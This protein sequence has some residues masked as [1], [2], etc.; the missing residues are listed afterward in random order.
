MK[1]THVLL[2]WYR[3]F[4]INYLPY[5]DRREGTLSRPW[6]L[7]GSS[8]E[9]A[10]KFIEIPIKSDIT[11]IVG[12]NESGKSHL[13]SAINKVLNGVG[14]PDADEKQ[15]EFHFTDLC[16]YAGEQ[17]KNIETWPNIGLRFSC[18]HEEMT[19]VTSS[20]NAK[21]K[22]LSKAFTLV[23]DRRGSQHAILYIDGEPAIPLS[24]EQLKSIR[25]T[26]PTV[27][28]I[29]STRPMSDEIEIEDLL[30]ALASGT[31]KENS[32]YPFEAS[33][34]ALKFLTA[35]TLPG[36]GKAITAD[37][38]QS[39]SEM[40][41][42]LEKS[43]RR[44]HAKVELELQL[45]RDVLK[46]EPATLEQIARLGRTGRSFVD[47]LMSVWNHE[48]E[49]E[50]NLS[51]YWQQ[52]DAFRL[53]LNYKAGVFYFE[54]TDKTGAVYTFKER[55]SGLRYFLSYYIQA[56]ALESKAVL[57]GRK[58]C[59]FLMDEPDSFLSIVGQRNLMNVFESLVFQSKLELGTQLIY[60]THS[61]FL[62]NKNFPHRIRLVRKG[63]GE[64]GTQFVDEARVRRYEPV[65]SALGIDCAQ[66]L[67]MGESN[68]IVEGPTDQYLL[69]ELVRLYSVYG[70]PNELL[71]LNSI[72]LMSAESAPGVEK[73]LLASRWGDEPIPATVVI[74]D[75]DVE[76]KLQK[77]RVTGIA[78]GCKKLI[79]E[80]FVLLISDLVTPDGDGQPISTIEDIVPRNIYFSA[81]RSYLTEWY[82]REEV[83]EEVLEKASSLNCDKCVVECV[84]KF[85][86]DEVHGGK[87]YDKMGVLQ[88]VI[89]IVKS[90]LGTEDD[91]LNAEVEI[92]K[93][94]LVALCS[95]LRRK[96]AESKRES[97]AISTSG[98]IKRA[99]RDFF[100][101]F[102]SSANS[103]DLQLLLERCNTLAQYVGDDAK[104]LTEVSKKLLDRI[105][106]M[107][108]A[109]ISLVK[110]G[111]WGKWKKAL[112]KIRENPLSPEEVDFDDPRTEDVVVRKPDAKKDTRAT[113]EIEPK[114]NKKLAANAPVSVKNNPKDVPPSAS[115]E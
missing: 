5:S 104:G 37:L 109:D 67:F 61:P 14:I 4:N 66:T 10:Y 113:E 64:E 83:S 24:D 9:D 20:I 44:H 17:K 71:D 36:A 107:R 11:T 47:G 77:D 39:V 92:L 54:I 105:H 85:F 68:V 87:T 13:V 74:F 58:E 76:G 94:T 89:S 97:K 81:L 91:H 35:L 15:K 93:K 23:L 60:T 55:S 53:G 63:D 41:Q 56:K 46:I 101:R 59:I 7:I 49:R 57:E 99:V 88:E 50:L 40:Q 21:P 27:E 1:I 48:L 8:D 82:S 16:H 42:N 2:R 75:D 103:F 100:K 19:T 43:K 30:S 84:S 38:H 22:S 98:T 96:I 65:R 102:K 72:V 110:D 45:F 112:T 70:N 108:K 3:S 28:F 52:D 111:S 86:E 6:N 90:T 34:D 31:P 69:A 114:T 79:D 115:S 32:Y 78:R 26:L 62:I 51:H 12:G 18:D 25:E 95:E 80:K 29:R 106:Q 33:Q 73:I